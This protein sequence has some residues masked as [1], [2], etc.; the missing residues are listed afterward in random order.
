M[1]RRQFLQF[2]VALAVAAPLA[3]LG[4]APAGAQFA[5]PP[6]FD[7]TTWVPTGAQVAEWLE[8][9][10]LAVRTGVER[11]NDIVATVFVEHPN[12]DADRELY[13]A[14]ER[15]WTVLSSDRAAVAV[16][17]GAGYQAGRDGQPRFNPRY[18]APS[19]EAFGWYNSWGVGNFDYRLKRGEIKLPRSPGVTWP[20]G[21]RPLLWRDR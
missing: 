13:Q 11:F 1:N 15:A 7:P 2:T 8:Y 10:K 9:Y 16:S 17:Q 4:V 12:P 3:R 19:N 18:T 14:A 6:A 5:T 20:D 21:K